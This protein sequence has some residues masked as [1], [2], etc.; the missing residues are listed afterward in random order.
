M[1][2]QGSSHAFFE[3]RRYLNQ[4]IPIPDVLEKGRFPDLPK[5]DDET[6]TIDVAFMDPAT[7]D[8]F[9]ELNDA[10][11][12]YIQYFMPPTKG[13]ARRLTAHKPGCETGGDL[14][15]IDYL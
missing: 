1:D 9:A 10:R 8:R 12:C 11:P 15:T 5:H 7:N 2:D 13:Q 6:R 4:A 3:Q 14:A